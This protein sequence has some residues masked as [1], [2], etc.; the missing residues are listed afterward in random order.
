VRELRP[1]NPFDR[2]AFG[3]QTILNADCFDWLERAQPHA[4]S[5]VVTDPPY[6]FF[7]YEA[8]EQRKLRSGRGGVWRIP[9]A[10]DGARRRALPRFTVLSSDDKSSLFNFYVRF[11]KLLLRALKPGAHVAIASNV[12]LSPIVAA[13]FDEGGFERRGEIVRLVRTFRGGDRPKGSENEFSM[14]STMPRSCWEPWGLYRAPLSERTVAANL[15]VHGVGALRRI[16][17]ETPFLDVIE[18]ET[19][20][21]AERAIA[22]HPSLKPQRF[23][24]QL[25]R[26]LMP[27]ADG[28]LLD[29]FCGSGS[30]LAACEANGL[31][32][33]GIERDYKYFSLAIAGVPK[34]AAIRTEA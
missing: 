26:A 10:F 7:E 32:A 16:S 19:A 17:D 6:G 31:T 24:R 30:T 2:F 28:T 21:D 33:I 27:N 15:R 5:A 29:P 23:L 14:L 34:L 1:D 3:R 12:L 13:A 22:D 4:I 9:P 25:T 18:S 20:P 11:T 8:V